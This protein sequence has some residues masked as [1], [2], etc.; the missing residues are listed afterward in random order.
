MIPEEMIHQHLNHLAT[1]SEA[2]SK[3]H[4]LHVLAAPA[5]ALGP[6]G[7]PNPA[8]V[9]IAVYAIAADDTV[10]VDM[11]VARTVAAAGRDHVERGMLVLFAALA[12]QAWAV[13]PMDELAHK[14]RAQGRLFE[15][16]RVADMTVV[17]AA[18]RDG[19]R[20]ESKHWLSGPRAGTA[21]EVNLLVGAPPPGEGGLR[22]AKMVRAIVGLQ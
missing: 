8:Q 15:H 22:S 3:M 1:A 9:E 5:A 17:Y 20:W 14:L 6:L 2:D 19:R 7:L 10:D 13:L 4:H 21:D 11:F 18:C 12:Q 16:P